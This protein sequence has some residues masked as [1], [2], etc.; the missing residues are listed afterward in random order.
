MWLVKIRNGCTIRSV[1][2]FVAEAPNFNKTL[3]SE[4]SPTPAIL[5]TPLRIEMTQHQNFQKF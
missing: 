4:I 2:D 1:E 5:S 3:F